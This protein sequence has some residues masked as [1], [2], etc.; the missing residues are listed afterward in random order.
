ML[1]M[2]CATESAR[3]AVTIALLAG[4]ALMLMLFA[5]EIFRALRKFALAKATWFCAVFAQPCQCL[6]SW[7]QLNIQ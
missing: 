5:A 1:T 3:I 6:H 7:K 4:I 2:E